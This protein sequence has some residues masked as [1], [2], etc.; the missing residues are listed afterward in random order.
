MDNPTTPKNPEQIPGIF[1]QQMKKKIQDN[2]EI[3]IK[4]SSQKRYGMASASIRLFEYLGVEEVKQ[5][6]S[7]R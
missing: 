1:F 5:I 3:T 7:R 4:V 2:R 6:N